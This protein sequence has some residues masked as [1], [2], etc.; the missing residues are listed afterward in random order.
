MDIF[1]LLKITLVLF[2]AFLNI[3]LT[4]VVFLNNPKNLVNRIFS[5][6]AFLFFLWCVTLS[7][8]E[9]PLFLSSLFWIKATYIIATSYI[10]VQSWFSAIFP[11]S[12]PKKVKSVVIIASVLYFV[13]S[14]WLL[15]FT[16]YWVSGVVIDPLRGK[17]TI[18]GMVG[19]N[20]WMFFVWV[21]IMLTVFNFV[22][23]Y[24]RLNSLQ[25]LQANYFWLG[26]VLFGIAVTIFDGIWPVVLHDTR[27]FFIS[28][29]SNLF[30]SLPVAYIILRHRFLDIRFV[31]LK[32]LIYAFFIIFLA[33]IYSLGIAF[34]SVVVF[35]IPITFNGLGLAA[36]LSLVIIFSFMFFQAVFQKITDKI[37][38][39]NRYNPQALVAKIGRIVASSIELSYISEAIIKEFLTE[40]KIEAG[41][42]AIS[43]G[44]TVSRVRQIGEMEN[45][46]DNGQALCEIIEKIV[47][48]PGENV[49]VRDEIGESEEK[50]LMEKGKYNVIL[51]LIVGDELLG[52]IILGNKTSGQVYSTEDIKV[53]KILAPQIA[54][55]IKNA[56]SYEQTKE[57]SILLQ[58]RVERATQHLKQANDRLKDLDK[59]KDEFVS[60]TSHELR[61]PMTV[62]KGYV[63]RILNDKKEGDLSEKTKQRLQ[64]IY[65][66]TEKEIALVNDV[67]DISRIEAGT[68]TFEPKT[69]D[70]TKLAEGVKKEL[71]DSFAKK[72]ISLT[73]QRSAHKVKADENNV[74]QVFIN[75][76]TNT[77]KFTSEGGK[78][79]IQFKKSG[80]LVEISISDTGMG[81][82]KSDFSKLF[83]KFGRLGST[84][85]PESAA[86]TGLGLYICKKMVERSGGQISV[87]SEIGK[88]ST[89][90]FSL[91]N[92]S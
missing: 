55:A 73:V 92:A 30:F 28:T 61:T 76:L 54:I 31:I 35:G 37:F 32:T 81:I 4:A 29:S 64:L 34:F 23:K 26:F 12:V 49:L 15:F 24:K 84:L 1:F 91:P 27:L 22:V 47:R 75:L 70:V 14:V 25:K 7:L 86:G 9:F 16:N 48:A 90:T 46:S 40:I 69:F 39:R 20:V 68:M 42:L 3:S 8:Y 65:D 62:I 57:F 17:Q 36:A 13:F 53:L 56:L 82:K 43:K 41:A 67:L 19:Y 33:V 83:T 51:P 44:G 58:I 71:A 60:I 11:I 2:I 74:H 21:F 88:G 89:F 80:E 6:I 72:K 52:A 78:V 50:K 18:L 79:K 63:W 66:A 87:K 77:V 38:Y 85:T 59:L 5:L 10:I 45:P